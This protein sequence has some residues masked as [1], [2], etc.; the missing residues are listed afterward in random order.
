MDEL[1]KD[2]KSLIISSLNLDDVTPEQIV[3]DAPLFQEGLGLDSIDALELA[4]AIERK[5][6]VTIPDEAVGKRVFSSVTALAEYVGA[7][8]PRLKANSS[9]SHFCSVAAAAPPSVDELTAKLEASSK[10]VTSLSGE[11][12]QRNKL[13]LF[14]QELRSKG[15]LYFQRPRKIRWE[16]LDPD[17]S[18]LVLDGERATLR[19]PGA[20]PQ[21]FDLTKDA[22]MRMVFDQLLTWLGPGSMTQARADY[23]LSV[24]AGPILVLVPKAGSPIAKAFSRIELR[25]DAKTLLMKSILLTE[26]NGDEKEIT[27]TKLTRNGPLPADAFQ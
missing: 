20:A 10:D 17:P 16:Y 11:F 21:S 19:T 24:A 26:K 8:R 3:D 13:K 15:R 9:S 1:K 18:T 23:D 22:T 6:R 14:K 25:L 7:N 5:Y 27:F 2:I 12:T 4:V